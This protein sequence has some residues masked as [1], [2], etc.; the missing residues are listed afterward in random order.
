MGRFAVLLLVLA[1]GAF[2]PMAWAA[3]LGGEGRHKVAIIYNIL[4][5]VQWPEPGSRR[6]SF[7]LCI[8]EGDEVGAALS[9]L[10]GEHLGGRPIR[11]Q[12]EPAGGGS[13]DAVYLTPA[14]VA[15]VR[16]LSGSAVL[17]IASAHGMV[18]QG[19]MVN[20]V[21]DGRRV[22]FDIGVGAMRRA[23]LSV[24]AKVLRLAR[25]VRED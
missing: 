25:Y 14:T 22:G 6:A 23:Q 19:V 12:R 9:I 1:L 15:V 24:S 18:D 3:D 21:Q 8:L 2:R 11:V 5:F 13:C 17:T 20:L 4:S 7:T 16:Q 10:E